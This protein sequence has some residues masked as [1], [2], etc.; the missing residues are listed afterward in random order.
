MS[1]ALLFHYLMFNMF[2]M[3]IH[4][5]LGACNLFVELFHGLYCSGTMC[6]GVTVWFGWGGVVWYPDAGFSLHPD[7]TPPQP[8]HNVTPAHIVPE[9]YNP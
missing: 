9:Q 7:T 8:N 2:R 3:L 6:V 4:P 5:S 1:L